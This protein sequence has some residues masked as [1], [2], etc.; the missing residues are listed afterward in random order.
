MCAVMRRVRRRRGAAEYFD[1]S[2]SQITPPFVDQ[3]EHLQQQLT[4]GHKQKKADTV[5]VSRDNFLSNTI[6]DLIFS[7]LHIQVFPSL[8]EAMKHPTTSSNTR[9]IIDLDSLETP[10]LRMLND[11]R[12]QR[13][14]IPQYQITLLTAGRKPEIVRFIQLAVECQVIER[15]VPPVVLKKALSSLNDNHTPQVNNV[16]RFSSKEWAILLAF[17]RGE[18]LKSIAAFLDKPYHH[19]IYIFNALLARLLLDN[20]HKLVHL[21]YEISF[22]SATLP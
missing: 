15:R 7:H 6:T 3:F 1:P 21:L 8:G 14:A 20:R 13:N 19:I 17:S 2:S 12:Q 22:A 9:L 5:L 10:T 11:I 16:P 4:G 18:S